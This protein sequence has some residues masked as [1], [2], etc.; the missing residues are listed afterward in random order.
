MKDGGDST[1]MCVGCGL[2]RSKRHFHRQLHGSRKAPELKAREK[3]LTVVS[4][5]GE[6][7][8]AVTLERS[9]LEESGDVFIFGSG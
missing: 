2:G 3:L 9:A 7:C 1:V 5:R 6:S 4:V 8:R